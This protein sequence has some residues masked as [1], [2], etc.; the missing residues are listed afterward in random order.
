MPLTLPPG[1]LPVVQ[2]K[3]TVDLLVGGRVTDYR[4]DLLD[5]EENLIG[6]LDSVSPE[7]SLD[8]TTATAIKGGGSITVTDV[9]GHGIDWLNVRIRPAV[10]LS[11]DGGGPVAEYPLGV[12]LVSAPV[13]TMTAEGST[14]AIELLDKLSILDQDIVTDDSLMPVSFVAPINANVIATVVDLIQGCGEATPAL[15][16]GAETL[17]ASMVWEVGVPVLQ[18]VNELLEAAG[19]FSL[20]TDG[21]GQ[22]RADKYVAPSARP[23]IYE[24]ANPFSAGESSLMSPEWTH[25]RDIYGVPNRYVAISQGSGETEGLIAVATN[26]SPSSPYSFQARGRWITRTVTGVEATSQAELQTRAQMGLSGASAVTSALSIQHVFLPELRINQA[27]RFIN[28][29]IGLNL[30]CYVTK[31]DVPFDPTEL[32]RT[33]L[34]EAVI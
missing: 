24:A 12:F 20:Y 15:T 19:Y 17:A 9:D 6:V 26:E 13:R 29:G 18:I 22:Y 33:E 16:P 32:C 10:L 34:R 25:D 23:P 2:F 5:S 11:S 30:L 21:A 3:P 1:T 27:V 28:P 14:L 4:F 31:T 8:W 7:G